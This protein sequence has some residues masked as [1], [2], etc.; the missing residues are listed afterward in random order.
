MLKEP[1]RPERV[2]RPPPI[3][4]TLQKVIK[5]HSPVSPAYQRP[6]SRTPS[7]ITSPFIPASPSSPYYGPNTLPKKV[8]LAK[9]SRFSTGL[10]PEA[11]TEYS[12]APPAFQ[13]PRSRV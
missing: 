8:I 1:V 12:P 11:I 7:P 5:E 2:M 3:T 6:S 13:T 10:D 9:V 4:L